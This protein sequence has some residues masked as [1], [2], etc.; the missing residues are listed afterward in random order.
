V[1]TRQHCRHVTV[2]FIS[3][4]DVAA[5]SVLR[6]GKSDRTAIPGKRAILVGYDY[7]MTVAVGLPDVDIKFKY[8]Q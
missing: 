8:L 2:G 3:W 5:Q 4:F 6:R 1:A 7:Y